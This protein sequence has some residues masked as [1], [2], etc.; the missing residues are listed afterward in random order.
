MNQPCLCGRIVNATARLSK[1]RFSHEH[2]GRVNAN[3]RRIRS[4]EK[5]LEVDM[6]DGRLRSL[7]PLYG[8]GRGAVFPTTGYRTGNS[9]ARRRL[10][11]RTTCTHRGESRRTSYGLRYRDELG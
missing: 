4:T 10:R 3:I 6:D 1:R 5:S 8:K 11:S 2:D 7:F 9:A